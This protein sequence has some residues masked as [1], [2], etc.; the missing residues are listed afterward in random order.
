MKKTSWINLLLSLVSGANRLRSV[1]VRHHKRRLIT[2]YFIYK[3]L[4]DFITNYGS[5]ILNIELNL[6]K[7]NLKTFEKSLS[8]KLYT[9]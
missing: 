3:R 1:Y 6:K 4:F 9:S 2:D 5:M 7:T 8:G